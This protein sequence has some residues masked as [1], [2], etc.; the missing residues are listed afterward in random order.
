MASLLACIDGSPH[1]ESVCDHS[2]WLSRRL[3]APVTLLHVQ[4]AAASGQKVANGA[5]VFLDDEGSGAAK[6]LLLNARQRLLQQGLTL[7]AQILQR[8]DGLI[9]TL[10]TLEA[11]T[12]L[13]VIGKRG[14]RSGANGIGSQLE[15]VVRAVHRPI[16]VCSGPFK[17]P[18]QF[19]IAY[20]GREATH[21][22]VLALARS[23]L[24]AGMSGTLLR[25]GEDD[26]TLRKRLEDL[27]LLLRSAGCRIDTTVARGDVERIVPRH[28]D[29]RRADL[30]I[31]GAYSHS[32]V[33][34]FLR[35][36]RTTQLLHKT[37]VPLLLLR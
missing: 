9:D 28:L 35:G 30:L 10:K 2:A 23:P 21:Q 12:R 22:G 7:P 11:D 18:R 1:A 32:S 4:E 15:A 34:R 19:T 8:P 3:D 5:P 20:D 27:A 6:A 13:L 31:M 14:E 25:V 33:W 26:P 24:L 37:E 16:L 29:E 17:T 36:S